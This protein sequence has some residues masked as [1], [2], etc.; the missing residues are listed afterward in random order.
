MGAVVFLLAMLCMSVIFV[1]FEIEKDVPGD[2][3]LFAIIV[4]VSAFLLCLFVFILMLQLY[5]V[6][7]LVVCFRMSFLAFHFR[8]LLRTYRRH[9][10][11]MVQAL[12]WNVPVIIM[13]HFLIDES[14]LMGIVAFAI[15]T[16]VPMRLM[17]LDGIRM[18]DYVML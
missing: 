9:R 14:M 17:R 15:L 7:A 11:K 1:R 12:G 13:S 3:I 8:E 5:A 10:S 2:E 18:K 4:A 6:L 16:I